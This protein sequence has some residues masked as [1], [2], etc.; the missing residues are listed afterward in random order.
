MKHRR[1]FLILSISVL[2]LSVFS[3]FSPSGILPVH[4]TTYLSDDFESFTTGWTVGVSLGTVNKTGTVYYGGSFSGRFYSTASSSMAYCWRDL[5]SPTTADH[6]YSFWIYIESYTGTDRITIIELYN[7][8]AATLSIYTG[9]T[10][11][12]S[13][14]YVQAYYSGAYHD[15]FTISATTWTQ[16]EAYYNY[17]SGKVHYYKNGAK[18]GGDWDSH[19]GA[20][21]KVNRAYVGDLSTTSG[22][23]NGHICID[24]L[25]VDN[26]PEPSPPSNN[27]V[28]L[29]SPPYANST[30]EAGIDF[31]FTATFYLGTI[32]NAS[33]L[34]YNDT[35]SFPLL[36]TVEN[37]TTVV[38][39]TANT[40][41]FRFTWRGSY[42]WNVRAYNTTTATYGSPN[43]TLT[44]TDTLPPKIIN[45]TSSFAWNETLISSSSSDGFLQRADSNYTI[46]HNSTTGTV[47]N[48]LNYSIV[49]MS[50]ISQYYVDRAYFFF[51]TSL[52]GLNVTSAELWLYGWNDGT[53]YWSTMNTSLVI[54]N[55]SPTYPHDPIVSG[56]FAY[57]NYSGGGGN[58]STTLWR[59]NAYNVLPLNATG[60]SWINTTGTTKFC[61]RTQ[62]DINHDTP[63]G[64]EFCD[65]ATAEY[66]KPPL[67][68][69]NIWNGTT[70]ATYQVNATW[71]DNF[72]VSQL[73]F[74]T[75]N[76]GSWT[77]TT[78]S[79]TWLNASACRGSQNLTLGYT[80]G[81]RVEIQWFATDVHGNVN[82]TWYQIIMIYSIPN[83]YAI[84]RFEY[85]PSNA[86]INVLILFNASQS[87]T[88]ATIDFYVWTFGDGNTTT[89]SSTTITHSYNA[90][91]TYEVSLNLTTTASNVTD[92]T[93]HELTIPEPISSDEYIVF[94]GAG[95]IIAI[96]GIVFAIAY[97]Q[98]H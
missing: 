45:S 94:L 21:I 97:S 74:S 68:I 78:L 16:V 35:G 62:R 67:L 32:Q 79:P 37:T 31:S 96:I 3:A 46:A 8:T 73:I 69:M 66:G 24:D 50:N 58:L 28:T 76:S 83:T 42:L 27:V 22:L 13:A 81:T 14:Y 71:N 47:Y 29:N 26:T 11:H 5:A 30:S 15:V 95:F 2:L 98:K 41:P 92:F 65:V 40:I 10:Y 19:G 84:A 6:H 64:L 4:A 25:S 85:S 48:T 61:L 91:G 82:D 57:G 93:F 89:T 55:G 1:L 33:L 88:T 51:N 20:S 12:D 59:I 43:R 54:Q 23:Q 80:S 9:L 63:T 86:T 38:N 18:Q 90:T 17:T 39:N 72:N 60:I 77:N 52:G 36:Y 7:T 34:I 53:L 56:D 44:V 49:G 70:G 87:Y 75:N